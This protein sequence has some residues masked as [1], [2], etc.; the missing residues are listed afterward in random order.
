MDVGDIHLNFIGGEWVKG[1][2]AAT[3]LNPSDLDNG[4]GEYARGDAV[5][6][7]SA[8]AAARAAFPEWAMRSPQ[9]RADILDRA[10]T[11]ILERREA[12]GRLLASEEGKILPEAIGD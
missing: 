11:L 12:L 7:A 9:D 4:V 8:V 2:D 10:G 3:N 6:A 1:P 5:Q